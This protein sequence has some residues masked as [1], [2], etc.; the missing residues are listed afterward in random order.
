MFLWPWLWEAAQPSQSRILWPTCP[1]VMLISDRDGEVSLWALLVLQL[2]KCFA[3]HTIIAP[4][5]DYWH[6]Q[7]H[8]LMGSELLWV[9]SIVQDDKRYQMQ[10]QKVCVWCGG[11]GG[12]K[13]T[14]PGI[15]LRSKIKICLNLL[16][17][18]NLK[19]PVPPKFQKDINYSRSLLSL[20]STLLQLRYF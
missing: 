19:G 20:L 8:L 17:W 3:Y 13:W 10:A 5:S 4:S 15:T 12:R 18:T 1:K 7:H 6:H 14:K 9:H 2:F 16:V 11:R